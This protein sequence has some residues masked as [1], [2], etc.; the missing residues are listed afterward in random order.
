[1]AVLLSSFSPLGINIDMNKNLG[2]SYSSFPQ[3]HLFKGSTPLRVRTF[4]VSSRKSVKFCIFHR[5]IH[6][7][8]S[9]LSLCLVG[10]QIQELVWQV[11]IRNC[12]W[13]DMVM[14]LMMTLGLN[15]RSV[16][17]FHNCFFL[18]CDE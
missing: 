16:F 15:L 17:F 9:F 3:I 2:V 13:N 4:V 7:V 5:I 14:M 1:M 8:L 12:C 11:R 18:V 6:K 10:F